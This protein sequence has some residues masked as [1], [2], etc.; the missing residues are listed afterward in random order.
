LVGRG[1]HRGVHDD[2]LMALPPWVRVTV[3]PD[4]WQTSAWEKI[5]AEAAS[6]P[7][8]GLRRDAHF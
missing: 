2:T 5:T 7:H 4:S 6:P 3:A 8:L 1:D